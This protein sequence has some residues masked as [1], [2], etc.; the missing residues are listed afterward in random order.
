MKFEMWNPVPILVTQ[1]PEDTA[2]V[3]D[4]KVYSWTNE[5]KNYL[6]ASE[7]EN[8]TT[9]Y[10]SAHNFIDM[11]GLQELY[12]VI[13]EC[14]VQYTF[15]LGLKLPNTF[16]IDSWINFF[17]RNQSEHEH[18]HYGNFLSG[19]YYVNAPEGSAAFSFPD[20]VRER[21]MWRGLFT[22]YIET[23]NF[24]NINSSSYVPNRGQLLMFQSWMPHSVLKHNSDEPR[25]SIAF[26]VNPIYET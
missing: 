11:C 4:K 7:G 22:K 23:E 15:N 25:I 24:L 9:S 18:T 10:H 1:V 26:N 5:N 8:L 6:I 21:Q 17:T 2:T 14:A 19:C 20:P 3:I 13:V 16:K 12:D